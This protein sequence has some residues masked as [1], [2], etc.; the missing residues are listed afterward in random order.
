M[1]NEPTAITSALDSIGDG[2]ARAA[3]GRKRLKIDDQEVENF[4][5]AEMVRVRTRLQHSERRED[6]T[7]PTIS[8]FNFSGVVY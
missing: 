3:S 4:G 6:G 2:L 7:I 1:A 8:T 5:P